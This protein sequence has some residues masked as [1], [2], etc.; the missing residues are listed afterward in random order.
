MLLNWEFL[1]LRSMTKRKRI[2]VF[3]M[4][5]SLILG[6]GMVTAQSSPDEANTQGTTTDY[7]PFTDSGGPD[8]VTTNPGEITS[9]NVTAEQ[10]TER[11]AGLFGNATG[12]IVLGSSDTDRLYEWDA[13]AEYVFASTNGSVDFTTLGTADAASLNGLSS[14]SYG[15][16]SDNATKTFST[17]SSS[18]YSGASTDAALTYNG[19]NSPVWTTA[20]EAATASPTQLSHYVFT[21][22]AQPD[23]GE[24]AYDGSTADYQVIVP[25]DGGVS[26][27]SL[28]MELQ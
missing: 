23:A 22:V 21:G 18:S 12:T 16:S 5:A 7:G 17:T 9:A 25:Q 14:L 11:W 24:T 26:S 8:T 1:R 2:A 4:V 3:A 15:D 20:L 27:Y 10:T 6:T 28:Y 13:R 19:G